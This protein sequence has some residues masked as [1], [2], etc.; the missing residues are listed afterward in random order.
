M[1][2]GAKGWRGR[3]GQGCVFGFVRKPGGFDEAARAVLCVIFSL[4]IC[5]S[6]VADSNAEFIVRNLRAVS[7][8]QYMRVACN[9]VEL[10]TWKD[11]PTQRCDYPSPSFGVKLPVVLIIPD[12]TRLRN[13]FETA[14]TDAK[15]SNIRTCA[16][17]LAIQAKCQ[18][19]N[20]FVVAGLVDEGRLFFLRD[21]VT[22]SV[23]VWT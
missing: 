22:V 15:L 7:W 10:P 5:T 19:N 8:G 2:A 21:G 17:K 1:S 14:C 6:T 18:S 11:L 9:P 20:Q 13:W 4:A 16:E 23:E 12:E 3:S